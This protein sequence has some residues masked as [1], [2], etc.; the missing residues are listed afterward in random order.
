MQVDVF[1][2]GSGTQAAVPCV[3]NAVNQLDILITFGNNQL[4]IELYDPNTLLLIAPVLPIAGP[5]RAQVPIS[6][7]FNGPATGNVL[8][9]IVDLGPGIYP[10]VFY[11][12]MVN[13]SA[14]QTITS[15]VCW[16]EDYRFGFNGMEKDNPPIV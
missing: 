15:T 11:V 5:P 10:D 6:L 3:A 2:P 4:Q 12:D 1:G 16:D 7:N 14:L 8:I 13:I 9:R